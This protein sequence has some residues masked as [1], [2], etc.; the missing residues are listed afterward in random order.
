[1]G[2]N[3]TFLKDGEKGQAVKVAAQL[4][5]F[6]NAAKSSLHIAIYDFRLK[7]KELSGPVIKALNDKAANGIEVQI[8]FYAGKP[9]AHTHGTKGKQQAEAVQEEDMN[10]FLAVGGDPAPG[11]T[12]G[13]LK[14]AFKDNVQ[15][16]GITGSKLMHNKYIIRDANTSEAALWT[17]SANFTDDAWS[18]QENN[19]VCIDGAPDI[20]AFYQND[21]K[22]LWVSGDIKSTGVNDRGSLQVGST[23]VDVAFAPGE[24]QTIDQTISDLIG[25]ARHRIKI[26][27]MVITSHAILGSLDDALR[28]DQ[29]SEFGGIYDATQMAQVVKLWQKSPNS[30]GIAQTFQEVASKLVG[31]H[32]Q[33]YSPTSKHDFMHNKVAV[34][35]DAVVTGSYNFSRSATQNAENI[36]ILHSKELAD[37][38]SEYID[39]L[40]KHYKAASTK[41]HSKT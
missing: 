9:Q 6:I 4:V 28:S 1:M 19:I 14:E 20:Y 21:F 39:E 7:Q 2:I 5:E 11:G 12:E 33:P 27:S 15:I 40:T 32:S 26:A 23:T 25:S 35:D 30:A 38:Y 8:A 34:C 29:V 17:G 3:V 36:V 37:K 10:F 13:F 24:G 18:F 22:E 31:K 16:K 41:S